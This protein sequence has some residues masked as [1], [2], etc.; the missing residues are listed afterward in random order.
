MLTPTQAQGRM[1]TTAQAAAELGVTPCRIQALIR[2][3]RL[4]AQK[5]GR[6]WQIHPRA[7]DAVRDRKP[8]RPRKLAASAK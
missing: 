1:L 4:V 8:G 6:D 5:I 3:G 7:L 2:K